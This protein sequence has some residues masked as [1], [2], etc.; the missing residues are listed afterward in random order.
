MGRCAVAAIGRPVLPLV[1]AGLSLA[2]CPVGAGQAARPEAGGA[3]RVSVGGAVALEYVRIGVPFKPYVRELRTPAGA[4]VLRDN[5][6]DHLHHHGLMFAVRAG[7]VNFWEET[8]GCGT[9]RSDR[10]RVTGSGVVDSLSWRAPGASRPLLLETRRIQVERATAPDAVLVTWQTTLALP[11][12]APAPVTLSGA[13]YHGLGMR[14]LQA[15]DGGAFET[16]GG[17][18]GTVFRGEE[19]L[20]TGRWCAYRADLSGR[21]VTVAMFDHP[22]N[23]RPATWFTMPRPFAYLAATLRLHETALALRSGKRLDLRYGV[24]ACD[25]RLNR[26]QL[27]KLCRVWLARA[28]RGR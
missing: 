17:D 3:V 11:Q 4:N 6:A 22:A 15:M 26:A 5:V 18:T 13:H 1:A 10:L 7:D 19:R 25:G 24:A 9:Q 2:A 8:P 12:G 21:P 16:D 14:F 27:D 23:P 28:G 20:M